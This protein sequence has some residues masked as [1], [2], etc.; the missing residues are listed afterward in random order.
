MAGQTAADEVCKYAYEGNLG[1]LR[2]KIEQDI[3]LAMKKDTV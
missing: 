2:L 3:R 1:L